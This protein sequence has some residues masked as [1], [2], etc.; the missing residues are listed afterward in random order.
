VRVHSF[1]D[2]EQIRVLK[3]DAS[4]LESM[5]FSA[6]GKLIA[7]LESGV[8]EQR[9]FVLR[10]ADAGESTKILLA[11][12]SRQVNLHAFS[13]EHNSF[14]SVDQ[15]YNLSLWDINTTRG[16]TF[17]AT[18]EQY[19]FSLKFSPDGQFLICGGAVRDPV[20]ISPVRKLLRLGPSDR[21]STEKY[22]GEIEVW[23]VATGKLSEELKDPR[24]S[25]VF[26]LAF[27]GD[28]KTLVAGDAD[29]HVWLLDFHSR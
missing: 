22:S 6:D 4:R 12:S 25:A 23:D 1:P 19:R 10:N 26:S 29:G 7:F 9:R 27:L 8:G 17:A 18:E 20:S 28:R 15:S 11:G 14:A 24:L 3:S 16:R 2:N 5:A 21:H 13:P